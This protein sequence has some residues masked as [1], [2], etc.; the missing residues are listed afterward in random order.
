MDFN[1]YGVKDN[2]GLDEVSEVFCDCFILEVKNKNEEDHVAKLRALI[3]LHSM[4]QTQ[5]MCIDNGKFK[6]ACSDCNVP[7]VMNFL[8]IINN[9]EYKLLVE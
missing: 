8:H 2:I 4:S 3:N 6:I 9:S 5:I 1:K 7:V